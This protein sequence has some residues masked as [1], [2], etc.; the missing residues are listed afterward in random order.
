MTKIDV[1]ENVSP[2]TRD[3]IDF[4]KWFES[5]KKNEKKIPCYYVDELRGTPCHT[6]HLSTDQSMS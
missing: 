1:S 6:T 2:D 3:I 5:T 4:S